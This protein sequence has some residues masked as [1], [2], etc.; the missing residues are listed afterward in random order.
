MLFSYLAQNET[1][2]ERC[3]MPSKTA[4]SFYGLILVALIFTGC[5]SDTS[6]TYNTTATSQYT[7]EQMDQM[8]TETVE[9]IIKIAKQVEAYIE[10]NPE[11][12]C[13]KADNIN[14]LFAL[15][16]ENGYPL[17]SLRPT[18]AFGNDLV[19]RHHFSTHSL[20]RKDYDLISLGEDGVQDLWKVT[21]HI[22]DTF[23]GQDIV[24]RHQSAVQD[25]S[26]FTHGPSIIRTK[27]TQHIAPA[28]GKVRMEY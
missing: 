15:L 13:P 25:R 14:D 10:A 8:N 11:V 5:S 28:P 21:D 9:S 2:Q 24:W 26:G 27:F 1:K 16:S 19:Y 7:L 20:N 18:D 6:M 17:D 22:R 3:I 12:G 23:Y 4:L